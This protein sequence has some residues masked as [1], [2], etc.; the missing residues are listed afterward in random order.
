M[1]SANECHRKC[2]L[3]LSITMLLVEHTMFNLDH[4]FRIRK[5]AAGIV[6]IHQT[7]NNKIGQA[8]KENKTFDG[9]Q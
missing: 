2:E 4:Y 6:E 1:S 7:A 5:L 3:L 8:A 9:R